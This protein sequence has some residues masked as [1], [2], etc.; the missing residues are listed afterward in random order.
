MFTIVSAE[1]DCFG[2]AAFKIARYFYFLITKGNLTL[3]YFTREKIQLVLTNRHHLFPR[4][5]C[6]LKL[7]R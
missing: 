2:L 4:D 5:V 6:Y 7:Q 1:N 3:L